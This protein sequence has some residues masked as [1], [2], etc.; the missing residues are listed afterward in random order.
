MY[1]KL[2]IALGAALAVGVL[3]LPVVQWPKL[4]EILLLLGLHS[5]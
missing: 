1:N 4:R 3:V 2:P 5:H